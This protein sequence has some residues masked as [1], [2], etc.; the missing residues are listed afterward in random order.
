MAAQAQ[1][2][3]HSGTDQ[4]GNCRS[5]EQ[6]LAGLAQVQQVQAQAGL[7]GAQ[8]AVDDLPSEPRSLAGGHRRGGGHEQRKQRPVRSGGPTA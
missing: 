5:C 1:A 8:R 4:P 6:A 3:G 2:T 7:A